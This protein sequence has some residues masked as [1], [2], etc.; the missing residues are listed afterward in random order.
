VAAATLAAS[1]NHQVAVRGAGQVS[2]SSAP[3][4]LSWLRRPSPPRNSS[5][6]PSSEEAGCR[7][8]LPALF[9]MPQAFII[10]GTLH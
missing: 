4:E 6:G 7:A 8:L 9:S 5:V 1:A 10:I 3:S 2:Q